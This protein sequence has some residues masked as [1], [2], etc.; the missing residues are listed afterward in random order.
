MGPARTVVEFVGDVVRVGLTERTKVRAL[1]QVLVER[2][3]EPV[4]SV[5]FQ[6]GGL[7]LLGDGCG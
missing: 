6:V 1:G 7:G 4:S 2:S 5:D 3:A